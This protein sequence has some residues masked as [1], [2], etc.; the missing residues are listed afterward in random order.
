MDKS[1][2]TRLEDLTAKHKSHGQ[3]EHYKYEV[4]HHGESQCYVCIYELPPE[5]EACPYH[6]HAAN[7]EVFY[8]ISGEGEFRTPEGRRAVRQG[9]VIVCPKGSGGAHKIINTS[10]TEKLVYLDSD[11]ENTPDVVTYPDSGKTG[12]MIAGE[13][14]AFY[15][16]ADAVDY[17]EGE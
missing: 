3:Y 1:V 9:D 7:T 15:K 13:S 17:Y 4:T 11:T 5:K 10:K 8:I 2:F 16:D 6:F 14:S 12:V